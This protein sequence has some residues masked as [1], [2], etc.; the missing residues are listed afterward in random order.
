MTGTIGDINS[1]DD[2]L[3]H[4]ISLRAAGIYDIFPQTCLHEFIK[5]WDAG[6]ADPNCLTTKLPE[7]TINLR[8][9]I[10]SLNAIS[11]QAAVETKRN[12]NRFL[13]RNLL[14]ETFRITQSYCQV[15]GKI[16][17]LTTESWYQFARII[18]NSISHNFRLKFRSND[19]KHLPVTYRDQTID[20]SMNGQS[21]SMPL[22]ILLNLIDDIISFV[23]D[24]L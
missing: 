10:E 24:R 19:M 20:A 16:N 11:S 1:K 22:E 13:T 7:G 3:N 18:V 5:K 14:K 6:E 15:N 21:L 2:L 17:I 12:A 9:F 4:L 8:E 23:R